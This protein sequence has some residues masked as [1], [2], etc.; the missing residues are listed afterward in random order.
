MIYIFY[1]INNN[2]NIPHIIVIIT[3]RNDT[4]PL[5]LPKAQ[6]WKLNTPV[7]SL[8]NSPPRLILLNITFKS[9]SQLQNIIIKKKFLIFVKLLTRK[10][11]FIILFTMKWKKLSMI[12]I[13]YYINNN[14]NIPHI[15][16]IITRR[17]ELLLLA[18][19]RF[20]VLKLNTPALVLLLKLPP[21]K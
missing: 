6:L 3:R 17:N 19:P 20:Q 21:R 15:I 14:L 9:F 4:L 10:I 13:F 16:V 7:L 2:L 8:L 5:E 12:Y 1:Y 11:Y 18:L